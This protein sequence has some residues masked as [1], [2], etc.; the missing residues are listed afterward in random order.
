[1]QTE[2]QRSIRM[3]SPALIQDTVRDMSPDPPSYETEVGTVFLYDRL[4]AMPT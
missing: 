2:T 3:I 4:Q 1:M